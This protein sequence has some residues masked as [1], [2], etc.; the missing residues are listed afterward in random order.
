MVLGM[1]AAM[2]MVVHAGVAIALC[3]FVYLIWRRVDEWDLRLMALCAAA[4]LATPY[5]FYYELPIFVIPL[6]LVAKRAVETDWLP[7][8]RT[9]L[10]MLWAA[11]LFITNF[12][13]VFFVPFAAIITM[14]AFLITARRPAFAL[15][16]SPSGTA[17]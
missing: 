2:A 13:A 12:D 17:P 14:A 6:L 15:Q 9:G 16:K 7:G 3:V 1:P 11:P 8:E 10:I 5:A 4:A